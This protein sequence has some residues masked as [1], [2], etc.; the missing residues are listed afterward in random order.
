MVN[1]S[2][3]SVGIFTTYPHADLGTDGHVK[4]VN[5]QLEEHPLHDGLKINS[6]FS[7]EGKVVLDGGCGSGLK[8]VRLAQAGPKLVIGVDGSPVAIERAKKLSDHFDLSNTSF[9]NDFLENVPQ[10]LEKLDVPQVDLVVSYHNIHHV[11]DWRKQTEIYYDIL[12]DGGVIFINF[13]EP[14]QGWGGFLFKNKIAY[15]LGRT[16]E[17][18]IRV[19]QILFGWRDKRWNHH[20]T[21]WKSFCI[22][23]YSAYYHFITVG[24]MARHLDSLGFNVIE[25]VPARNAEDWIGQAI[26]TPRNDKLKQMLMGSKMLRGMFTVALRSRQWF[27]SGDCRALV[28]QKPE[29]Q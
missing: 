12:S 13:I 3:E 20:D 27:G 1:I 15:H 17:G 19:G 28:C 25:A 10:V 14:T 9:V 23:R 24:M 5:Q 8:S 26:S 7:L 2:E 4:I 6:F 22:D 18:R 11:S 16:I 29:K 21:D